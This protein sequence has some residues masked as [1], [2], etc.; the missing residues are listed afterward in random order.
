MLGSRFLLQRSERTTYE[1]HVIMQNQETDSMK[2]NH[3]SANGWTHREQFFSYNFANILGHSEM[4]NLTGLSKFFTT[5]WPYTFLRSVANLLFHWISG[6]YF[7]SE[8]SEHSRLTNLIEFIDHLPVNKL[9]A[10]GL[11]WRKR[12]PLRENSVCFITREQFKMIE[13]KVN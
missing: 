3:D 7:W 5:I 11:C 1:L 10:S 4:I 12:K 8:I 2:T 6:Q 13:N 9:T